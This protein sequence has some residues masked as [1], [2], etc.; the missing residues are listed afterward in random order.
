MRQTEE[1]WATLLL[2]DIAT[3]TDNME[4]ALI[5]TPTEVLGKDS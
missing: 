5:E 2:Q 3:L 1:K 4:E